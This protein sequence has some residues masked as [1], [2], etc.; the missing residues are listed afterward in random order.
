MATPSMRET[1]GRV[2][3]LEFD[4]HGNFGRG[5]A[6]TRWPRNSRAPLC[7]SGSRA[8]LVALQV[9]EGHV[10]LIRQTRRRGRLRVWT[11]CNRR[12]RRTAERTTVA[13]NSP[14]NTFSSPCS[15][16]HENLFR[17]A[18]LPESQVSRFTNTSA[19]M[20]SSSTPLNTSTVCRCRRNSDRTSR[21][22]RCRAPSAEME[23]PGPPNRKPAAGLPGRRSRAWPPPPARRPES[24]RC[25]A[26][27][28]R[29]TQS[30]SETADDPGLLPPTLRRWTSRFSQRVSRRAEEKNQ[31]DGIKLHGFERSAGPTGTQAERNSDRYEQQSHDQHPTRTEIFTSQP[32]RCRPNRMI[33]APAIGASRRAIANQERAHGAGRSAKRDEH[34]RESEHE[35]ERR[36]QKAP[37]GALSL[38]QLL[39]A[40]ARKHRD[41][42]RDERQDT[43]REKRDQPS[44][45]RRKYGNIHQNPSALASRGLSDAP[46]RTRG[47]AS[48]AILAYP[49]DVWTRCFDSTS[50]SNSQPRAGMVPERPRSPS[51][52]NDPR[53]FTQ[54]APELPRDASCASRLLL[55]MH[56]RSP[57]AALRSSAGRSAAAPRATPARES[58]GNR[59]GRQ[60]GDIGGPARTTSARTDG[61]RFS[62]D[63]DLALAEPRRGNRRRG[64]QNGVHVL[65]GRVEILLPSRALWLSARR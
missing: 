56:A 19:P 57:A 21:N 37:R 46:D 47:S 45:E 3:L 49:L 31:R 36:A 8:A 2:F 20:A 16:H 54:T 44:D 50:G 18:S 4:Q 13:N 33:S 38:L 29:R 40:D 12:R 27:S 63:L 9:L 7:P 34:D 5:R 60:A 15:D 26:S 10:R 6:R 51:P 55:R 39:D 53:T 61:L 23:S 48:I 1:L 62:R 24:A 52:I 59:N 64:S 11:C 43:R 41:V 42:A 32:T 58:A 35:R 65:E 22:R 25:T 30:P 17:N 28:R 14:V